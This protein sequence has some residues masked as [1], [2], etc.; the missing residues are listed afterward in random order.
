MNWLN[1]ILYFLLFGLSFLPLLQVQTPAEESEKDDEEKE[2]EINE[3]LDLYG[4]SPDQEEKIFDQVEDLDIDA[5]LEAVRQ[6]DNK[7][8]DQK[9]I[10][11][12]DVRMKKEPEKS[13]DAT[14]DNTADETKLDDK[15]ITDD[16]TPSG[17]KPGAEPKPPKPEDADKTA[18]Y[19]K[20]FIVDDKFIA[21]AVAKFRE[22]N[23]DD[24]DVDAKAIEYQ[25][26]LET[27]KGD[28][29][30]QH[31]LNIHVNAQKYIKQI[32]SPF[33]PEFKLSQDTK[34]S[35]EYIE[36]ATTKKNEMLLNAIRGAGYVDFPEDGL[37]NPEAKREFEKEL[38]AEDPRGFRKYEN[39]ID[40]REAAIN[41]QF[42]Q[43]YYITE[44]WESM[45]RDV[46]QTDVALFNAYLKEKKIDPI[47]IGVPDLTLDD[48][49]NNPFLYENILMPNGKVNPDVI[50]M[51]DG[52]I[53]IVKPMSVFNQL[54]EIFEDDIIAYHAEIA[55]AEGYQ[56]G[57]KAIIEPS[58][59][60][61]PGSG[62]IDITD[63]ANVLEN[64]D[65][66]LEQLDK[67]LNKTK[68]SIIGGGKKRR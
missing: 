28:P 33:N 53:P 16:Q 47:K 55:R 27:V 4:L 61:S 64:D 29:F 62:K 57:R 2:L 40:S 13:G 23:K 56:A 52:N 3:D 10:Y 8:A 67:L 51:M 18:K 63:D 48:K 6:I 7:P 19:T 66:T 9:H 49:N 36:K 21:D 22:K 17:T 65:A 43:W 35:K 25:K 32:N 50:T 15:T 1:T 39:L 37:T 30:N 26:A 12:K 34:S 60:N 5:Y 45:A 59:S 38:Y 24:K 31:N 20:V 58:M 11:L 68:A 44:N 14:D 41:K 46:V 54:K 42:D